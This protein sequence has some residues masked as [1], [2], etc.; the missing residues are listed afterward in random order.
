MI[1]IGGIMKM[2][3]ITT[4][5]TKVCLVSIAAAS[6]AACSTYT[7]KKI[8]DAT[9]Q[10]LPPDGV[11]YSLVK[12]EYTLTRTPPAA[13]AKTPTYEIKVNYVPDHTQRYS[14]KV[15]PGIFT[16]PEFALKFGDGGTL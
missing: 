12:P 9:G 16:N 15:D 11:P 6:M 5:F 8:G 2:L 13:G 14:V 4:M 7:G 3:R 10:L 1:S